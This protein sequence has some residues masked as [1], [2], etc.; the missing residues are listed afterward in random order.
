MR[1]K[2]FMMRREVAG[3][4][5]LLLAGAAYGQPPTAGSPTELEQRSKA[6]YKLGLV[7]LELQEYD[8]AI[9]EFETGYEYKPLP[10]F[11]YNIGRVAALAGHRLMAVEYYEKYLEAKPNAPERVEV[12][13]RI[14]DLQHSL[15]ERPEPPAEKAPPVATTTEPEPVSPP[16]APVVEAPV[17]TQS[18]TAEAPPPKKSHKV[19]IAL[20]IVGGVLVVGAAV[21][22]GVVLSS[23]SSNLNNWGTL[24]VSGSH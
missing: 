18:V 10:L 17:L 15:A 1:A 14:R 12:G 8:A 6:H 7:H 20:G 22:I 4:L 21:A 24:T 9:R 16:P 13:Q 19:G 5:C 2:M 23:Q 11:L 3:V